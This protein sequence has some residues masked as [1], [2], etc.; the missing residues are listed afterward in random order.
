[1]QDE[2]EKFRASGKNNTY[3]IF[4]HADNCF[5]HDEKDLAMKHFIYQTIAYKNNAGIV[6]LFV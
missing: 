3:L 4:N 1:M 6:C 2:I 5:L